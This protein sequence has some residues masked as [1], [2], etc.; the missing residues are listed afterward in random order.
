MILNA[1]KRGFIPSMFIVEARR[2]MIQM[3][4]SVVVK[5]SVLHD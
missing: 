4:I 1:L 3:N 2:K 5:N